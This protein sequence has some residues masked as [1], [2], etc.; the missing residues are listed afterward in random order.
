MMS[1]VMA[2]RLVTDFLISCVI[3]RKL[4]TY[5]EFLAKFPQ[6]LNLRPLLHRGSCWT[7]R[8][9]RL[10]RMWTFEKERLDECCQNIQ[11][12]EIGFHF[13]WRVFPIE[14]NWKI[15]SQCLVCTTL[16]LHTHTFTT[17]AFLCAAGGLDWTFLCRSAQDFIHCW[18]ETS[19][20]LISFSAS[21]DSSFKSCCLP[22]RV[23]CLIQA[24]KV[25][26]FVDKKKKMITTFDFKLLN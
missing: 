15:Y 9:K 5:P 12:S 10:M 3:E 18:D 23:N 13:Y 16:K 8:E 11:N 21:S 19:G 20:K 25:N 2:L 1:G 24:A 26:F 22:I 17:L 14:L 4:I 7:R 6:L